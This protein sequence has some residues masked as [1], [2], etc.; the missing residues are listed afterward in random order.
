MTTPSKK[1]AITPS[2]FEN[3]F[4]LDMISVFDQH[5][6]FPE[7]VQMARNAVAVATSIHEVVAAL[8]AP[9]DLDA[10]LKS[11]KLDAASYQSLVEKA[12]VLAQDA[13]MNVVSLGGADTAAKTIMG[14]MTAKGG[15]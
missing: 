8:Y 11:G 10:D 7:G 6:E 13:K 3:Q 9:G 14:V 15:V 4:G 2:D 5:F 12:L 1:Q